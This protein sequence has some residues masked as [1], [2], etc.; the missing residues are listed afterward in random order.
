MY[1]LNLPVGIGETTGNVSEVAQSQNGKVHTWDCPGVN[2]HFSLFNSDNL[3]YFHS[4]DRI[5]ILYCDSPKVIK[6]MIMVLAKIKPTNTYLVRT[7]C[8][9]WEAG[10]NKTIQ[11][12]LE[13]DR[14]V[15][16]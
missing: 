2:E 11:Q 6:E 15:I 3:S 9:T 12:E 13:T 16:G 5:F 1:N 7:K 10:H 14:G 8:D 4:A